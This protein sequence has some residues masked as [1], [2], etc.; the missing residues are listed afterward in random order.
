MAEH[1]PSTG[2]PSAGEPLSHALHDLLHH[3][4]E[5]LIQGWNWKS[6][7]ISILVR[8]GIF[9]T[10]NLR[11]GGHRA[12]RAALVEAVVA[13]LAAGV[14]GA[15]TQRLRDARPIAATLLIVW[16]LM[17]AAMVGSEA[18][19]HHLF[20]TPHI[21][22]GLIVSFCLASVASGFAWFAQRRG[23]MLAGRAHLS[24]AHDLRELP[25]VILDFLLFLPRAILRGLGALPR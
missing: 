4:I 11:A 14:M 3:P 17:P 7:A 1:P 5:N 15:L 13:V 10:T 23:V 8:S 18:T 2:Y 20:A 16:L 9:F 12:L 19:V 6:G 22:T 24:I 21:R 25:A